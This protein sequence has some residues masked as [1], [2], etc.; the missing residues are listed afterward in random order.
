MQGDVKTILVS[1]MTLLYRQSQ[2]PDS[3]ENSRDIV[4]TLIQDINVTEAGT[5][6]SNEREIILGLK[7]IVLEMCSNPNDSEYDLNQFLQR[8]KVVCGLDDRI[9][10]AIEQGV[11]PE[12]SEKALKRNVISLEKYV[13]STI[14]EKSILEVVRKASTDFTFHREKIKDLDQFIAEQISQLEALQKTTASKDASLMAEL[15][16][17]DETQLNNIFQASKES[18][19]G[20]A[21][22]KTGWKKLDRMLRG[23]I[24]PK[25][26]MVPLALSHNY[27]TGFGLSVFC[28]VALC[29]KPF[30]KN[31]NKKPLLLRI[32]FEDE[33]EDNIKL[34]YDYLKYT[35][36]GQATDIQNTTKEEMASYVKQVLSRNGFHTKMLRVNPSGW[37]YRDIFNAFLEYEAQGY[38]IEGMFLDYLMLISRAGC[39][40][41]P[42]GADMED[43]LRRLRN[44]CAA[45]GCFLF[46]PHQLNSNVKKMLE[47]GLPE[48]LLA[49]SLPG[50][51]A[52]KGCGTLDT[53]LDIEIFLHKFKRGDTWWLAVAL[54]KHRKS[55]VIQNDEWK[56]F[57]LPFPNT[58]PDKMPIPGDWNMDGEV[59][60]YKLPPITNQ[61]DSD[62]YEI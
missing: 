3:S 31:P 48:H 29:N 49:K 30:T 12:L 53:E 5:V 35:E 38:Q 61:T 52:A 28:G 13:R 41:G 23:G 39:I 46:N 57:Y 50:K 4:R 26:T 40:Q 43:L 58:K 27:K 55:G 60:V 6:F 8:A 10:T 14:R 62:L 56:S 19:S 2:L 47:N 51:Q 17:T 37:T 21:V 34:L 25:D 42:M 16:L 1:C 44:F 9:Y 54:G 7:K 15:D 20:Q 59:G 24:R 33:I 36:T 18:S 32:S 11:K 22:Y 45:K